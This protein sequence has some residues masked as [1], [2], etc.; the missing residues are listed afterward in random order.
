[1]LHEKINPGINVTLILWVSQV[2]YESQNMKNVMGKLGHYDKGCR[3]P[4]GSEYNSPHCKGAKC[5]RHYVTAF[6]ATVGSMQECC[7]R[8]SILALTLL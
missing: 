1:M 3:E 5:I 6:C 2:G 7:T 8:K 4:W